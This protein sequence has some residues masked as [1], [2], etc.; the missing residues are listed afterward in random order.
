MYYTTF[1][2]LSTRTLFY[3]FSGIIACQSE[4]PK[5]AKTSDFLTLKSNLETRKD[6]AA[7]DAL[8]FFLVDHYMDLTGFERRELRE[9]LEKHA[10]WSI[11]TT[12]PATEPGAKIILHGQLTDENGN[13]LPGE[14]I[15]VF[16]TNY[17]GYYAPTD[18]AS[19]KMGEND[20]RLEGFLTTDSLGRFELHT[21]RP[22][23]YPKQYQGRTIPAHVHMV[24]AVPGFREENFQ[25]V[26]EDDPAMTTYWVA[27]AQK[28]SNPIVSLKMTETGNV[29]E[30][31]LK[32]IR[33]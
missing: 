32:L 15:H 12:C 9:A 29:G 26:F 20:A 6:Q 17:Q 16:H 18:S 1:R 10:V 8:H 30:V 11:E 14:R 2:S 25:V 23:S 7:Y 19:G 22:A 28:L 3:L 27:W 31:N 24:V 13:P 5:T 4:T 33:K 21:I